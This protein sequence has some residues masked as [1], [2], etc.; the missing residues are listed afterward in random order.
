MGLRWS[1]AM[2]MALSLGVLAACGDDDEVDEA[3]VIVEEPEAEVAVVE[4][5]IADGAVSTD[6]AEAVVVGE[7]AEVAAEEEV[8]AEAGDEEAVELETT[9]ESD[10]EPITAEVG[11]EAEDAAE[12]VEDA[13]ADAGDA[14]E[15]ATEEAATEVEET[16]DA[17]EA[18]AE[19]AVDAIETEVAEAETGVEAEVEQ[20]ADAAEDAAEEA[21]D[22]VQT[23]TTNVTVVEE[24]DPPTEQD[25]NQALGADDAVGENSTDA[26]ALIA[27]G[28]SEDAQVEEIND[29]ATDGLDSASEVEMIDFDNLVLDEEGVQT[30]TTF[31]EGSDAISDTQKITIVAGIDAAR[32]NPERLAE[33]LEQVREITGGAVAT[34]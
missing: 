6:D 26:E 5:G 13:A 8:I 4:E 32:D 23:L 33:L 3:E 16:A 11:A 9:V 2:A 20:A 24:T 21:E 12:E 27:P 28:A 22:G 10:G 30:L 18:E 25:V 14:V 7:D 29:V 17:V 19:E 34:E 15:E 1:T 31:V